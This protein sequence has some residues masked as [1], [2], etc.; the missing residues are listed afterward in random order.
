MSSIPPAITSPRLRRLIPAFQ[1]LIV[2]TVLF[3]VSLFS[4]PFAYHSQDTKDFFI[5][6]MVSSGEGAP[7]KIYNAWPPVNYP[8]FVIY[9]LIFLERIREL[10]QID[11][12]SLMTICLL[13][14][15]FLLAHGLGSLACYYGLR[16]HYGG[17]TARR[18]ALLYAC[19]IPLFVNGS[20]WG[21]AD[22]LMLLGMVAAL[23]L[24]VNEKPVLAGA[25]MG[26]ALTIK[27]QAVVLAPF[28]LTY[29]VR[30]F[31]WQQTL[32]GTGAGVGVVL[33][34]SLPF[35]LA[36][37][38][39]QVWESYVNAAGFYHFRSLNAMNF[40]G[41]LNIYD[42][43]IRKPPFTGDYINQDTLHA[44]GSITFQQIGLFMLAV[45]TLFLLFLLWRRP[46]RDRLFFTSAMGAYGLFI[47]ATQMHERYVVPAAALLALVGLFSRRRLVLYIGACFTASMNQILVLFSN[48]LNYTH[49]NGDLINIIWA[50]GFLPFSILNCA[51]FAYG[52]WLVLKPAADDAATDAV[53]FTPAPL[54]IPAASIAPV[55][56]EI[57]APK[58]PSPARKAPTAT[59]SA[60]AKLS[61]EKTAAGAA[62]AP[63][64]R[65]QS[66]SAQPK[67]PLKRV[68][69][70]TVY[71]RQKDDKGKGE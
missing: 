53:P 55:E 4:S 56:S 3:A 24:L 42:T 36:G 67:G 49:R 31:G 38:G 52:T 20:L 29:S 43:D 23:M 63:A 28:L 45:N 17:K 8:P 51:L 59:A 58:T 69:R 9:V 19:C 5:P 10:F 32:K 18:I 30:R 12:D 14:I 1:P 2:F 62:A 13:K 40:W 26:L 33:G 66:L 25:A 64:S 22:A 11:K 68:V 39:K 6:W 65:K 7:W 61:A 57:P 54:P 47:L 21:Q 60:P 34:L 41:A 71:V 35:V 44:F 16:R 70:R 46:T 27:V 50:K 15:P 37:Y 48:Y